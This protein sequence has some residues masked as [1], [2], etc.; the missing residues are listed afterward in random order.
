MATWGKI[1][2]PKIQHSKDPE[3][4]MCLVCP[5]YSKEASAAEVSEQEGKQWKMKSES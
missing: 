4:T 5:R 1:S 3:A 2:R